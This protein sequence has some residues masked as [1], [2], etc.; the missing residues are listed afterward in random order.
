MVCQTIMRNLIDRI[1][2]TFGYTRFPIIKYCRMP[3]AKSIRI[4]IIRTGEYDVL[5]DEDSG[6]TILRH[7]G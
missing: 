5:I 3:L 1:L 7:V 2:N 6:Q 4:V